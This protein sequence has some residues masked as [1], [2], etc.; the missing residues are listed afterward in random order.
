MG[1]IRNGD[2]VVINEVTV[3][4][5][6]IHNSPHDACTF[7][8]GS[9]IRGVQLA[10]KLYAPSEDTVIRSV[11]VS[12]D[13]VSVE[14]NTDF[15]MMLSDEA[16]RKDFVA[17]CKASAAETERNATVAHEW[18]ARP[19]KEAEHP[20]YRAW[21]CGVCEQWT[22]VKLDTPGAE[23]YA[24]QVDAGDGPKGCSGAPVVPDATDK[25][26]TS[27]VQ[28]IEAAADKRAR[29]AAKRKAAN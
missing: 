21:Q 10:G 15:L 27:S 8:P 5:R 28:A 18:E 23:E 4:H 13:G 9:G 25:S 7:D 29:K 3:S 24:A 20:G 6:A 2:G 26:I 12:F 11:N 14:C 22:T 17:K 19:E 1:Q 16:F